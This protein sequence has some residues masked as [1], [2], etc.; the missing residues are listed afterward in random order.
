MLR[1]VVSS[2]GVALALLGAC[3]TEPD[4]RPET[5]DYII[6]AIL[7]PSCGRGGCH[8]SETRAHDLAFDTIDAAEASMRSSDHGQKLVVPGEPTQSRLVTVLTDAH[9]PMPADAPLP[10]VDID[11]ITRWVADGAEGLE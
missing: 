3:G 8:S 10:D 9:S 1:A 5:A 6:V 4:T 7:A 2:A 11:L